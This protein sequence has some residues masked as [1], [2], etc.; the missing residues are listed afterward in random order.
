MDF[1]LL[2]LLGNIVWTVVFFVIALSIIVSIHEYGH[3]I[4]ARWCGIKADVFSIGFGPVIWSRADKRGT[5]W[6]IAALPLGGYVKFKG[7]S[8]AA[9]VASSDEASTMTDAERETT[10][11]GARLWKRALT[12]LAGPMFNFISAILVF[13][14]FFLIE[15]RATTDPIIGSVK[16]LPDD[17]VTLEAGDQVLALNG[18]LVET[19]GDLQEFGAVQSEGAEARYRILRD[20]EELE[21]EA[22]WPFLPL[23]S[24]VQ[25]RTAAIDAG[26]IQ[27]DFIRAVNGEPVVNFDDLISKVGKSDG[28]MLTLSIWR[29][30]ETIEVS[31]SPKRADLPLPDGG[32]ETRWLIGVTGGFFFEPIS[33][34]IGPLMAMWWGVQQTYGIMITSLSALWHMITGQISTCNLS[35]PIGIAETSGDAARLGAEQFVWFIAVLST[36][37]GLINLFPIPVLDGGH[38]VFYTYEAFFKKPPSA[39]VRNIM[40]I[41]GL[42]LIGSL[43]IFGLSQD[44]FCP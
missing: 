20:G 43:M 26:L 24:S 9:S 30:G 27:G 35:G 14:V 6:Q 32:F 38:L 1:S 44:I 2:P 7:D 18:V 34:P 31:L 10:M 23:I 25:P 39:W 8:D 21:I 12:V 3:Y 11:H 19:I 17:L 29:A 16:P 22:A 13:A 36:A 28:E 5:Q 37:V 41:G 4:V 42:I 33:E 40:M 15:G